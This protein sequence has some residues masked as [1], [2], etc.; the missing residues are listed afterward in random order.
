MRG[1]TEDQ[2]TTNHKCLVSKAFFVAGEREPECLPGEV[3]LLS[4]NATEPLLRNRRLRSWKTRRNEGP[5]LCYIRCV[6]FLRDGLKIDLP[7]VAN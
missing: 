6:S 2:L 7:A 1:H 3:G 5:L 4:A